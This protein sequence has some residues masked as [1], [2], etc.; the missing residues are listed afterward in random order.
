[1]GLPARLA[2]GLVGDA[3]RI[4]PGLHAWC[5]YYEDGWRVADASFGPSYAAP[6]LPADA[7]EAT[8]GEKL[9]GRMQDQ[10]LFMRLPLVF[11]LL[12]LLAIFLASSFRIMGKKAKTRSG[13]VSAATPAT[14]ELLLP[15]IRQALLSPDVWGKQGPL[16]DHRFLPVLQGRP[17]SIR[18]ALALLRRQRLLLTTARSPLAL[19]LA[20]GHG[21][22][23]VLDLS[24]ECFAPLFPL[25]AGAV[26]L[27]LLWKLQPQPPAKTGDPRG[28]LL[29]AVNAMLAGQRCGP[30]CCLLAPGL[31][32][33]DFMAV[34]LPAT[35]RRQGVFF[36]RRFIA[37][38]PSAGI[39]AECAALIEKNRLLAIFRFMEALRAGS[40]LPAADPQAFLRKAARRLLGNN[41]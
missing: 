32:E 22:R 4:E 6:S 11:V 35:P 2:I 23:P 24:Q 5:E 41:P 28:D 21:R 25:F 36:H 19:A 12:P 37:V 9:P 38:N 34:N 27:D 18:R 3:G 39:L 17:M 1:M 13:T 8:R 20:M 10:P 16:W 33:D 29:A 30:A 40:L 31:K 15:V 26:Q 14:R 7:M